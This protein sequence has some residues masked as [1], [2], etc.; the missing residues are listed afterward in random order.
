MSLSQEIA[1]LTFRS[2][3]SAGEGVRSLELGRDQ[4]GPAVGEAL[5]LSRTRALRMTRGLIET[6]PDTD[7]AAGEM[8]ALV[9]WAARRGS[10]ERR[11]VADA[12]RIS[13]GEVL[14]V[15][16]IARLPRMEARPFVA[17]WLDGGGDPGAVL[18]W[19][20]AVGSV[21]RSH[22]SAR[23]RPG[24]AGGVV[25][26]VKEAAEDVVDALSE[27]VETIVDA[28]LEAGK[29]IAD[30]VSE[31]VNWTI[32]EVGDL[33]EALLEAGM[34][35]GE[36]VADAVEAGTTIFKK[37]VKAL[38]EVGRTV[39]EVLGEVARQ[40]V[41]VV[42]DAIRALREI[43]VSF[44]S[45]LAEAAQLVAS[46]LR[47]VVEAL[48]EIGRSVVQILRAALEAAAEVLRD[49]VQALLDLGR[50]LTS[51]VGDVV[52]GRR[53]LIEAF[54]EALQAL[55]RT[56]AAI[57]DAARD[58]AGG[59][60]RAIAR[61]LT[62]IGTSIAALAEWAADA[63]TAFGREVI[64][65]LVE[66]GKSV[67]DL[68][69]AVA[70]RAFQVM[71][72]VVDGLFALGRTFAQLL[73]DLAD[74]AADLLEAFLR[75]AFSL[76]ATITE[77]VAETLEN[78]YAAAKGMIEAA[79][80]AGAS[81]GD[82]LVEAAKGGYFTLRKFVFGMMDLVGLGEIMRW[83][84]ERLERL[85][86]NLFHEVMTAI[87][88]AGGMLEEVLDWAARQS[89]E[90]FAAVVDA[91][92]SVR[93]DL[94]DLYRWA[95]GL[96]SDLAERVWREIGRATVRLRNSVTYVLNYLENDF[97]P[98]V[99]RFVRGLL[100]VGYELADLV[101]RLVRRGVQFLAEALS[102][103]LDMGVTLSELF[104]ATLQNPSLA[105]DNLLE[106]LRTIGTEWDEI[107]EAARDAGED[108]VR[109]VVETGR[110]LGEPVEEMLAGALE[111][112]GGLLGLVVSLL[113]NLLATYRP[114][115]EEEKAAAEPVFGDSLDLDQ[116]SISAESLDNEIIFG[117]QN[118]FD[119]D[120]DSRAFVTGTL[121][122]M[123]ASQPITTATLIHELTH[124]WQNFATGPMYLSEA[125]HAQVTD[126]DAYNYGYTDA[127]NGDGAEDE[128]EAAGGDFEAF[129]R[130]QQGQI[131]MHYYVRTFEEE[132]PEEEVA[133]W[134]PYIAA[135]QAAA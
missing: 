118:F 60:L 124:V 20:A 49:T 103:L 13:G 120:P 78:T 3:A 112:S 15:D 39:G 97:L 24:D 89:E 73:R 95:A 132:R 50:T 99:G 55:G 108:A 86:E 134:E 59:A 46:A 51:L 5:A 114:L 19:L 28:V 65:A 130:E 10:D 119:G 72:T 100:D 16:R 106:A 58:A 129:N 1:S 67:V 71:R 133:P 33:V 35:L 52:T 82:L 42:A 98:G 126:P 123:D 37:F 110:R 41:G 69:T 64:A 22:R 74:V 26:W 128:L 102:A 96:A 63:A 30:L 122:N 45:I 11:V 38:V 27:A 14:L 87:R 88:Y 111:V 6:A 44:A 36:L 80:R 7:Q 54:V 101:V 40:A 117:I 53:S 47:R 76:A 93:E 131:V 135:V 66:A 31:I 94:I 21:L 29:A 91:W 109:E 113:F 12:L 62:E 32:E 81:V 116:V 105:W 75:A 34:T 92:E 18:E 84:T 4:L 17:D 9:G 104:V 56:A 25:E 2:I 23:P 79:I 125:I 127:A 61:S 57:L 70:G 8:E 68:V 115:T 43:A 85:A 90:V 77:F 121:I 48:L 83:A 107:L